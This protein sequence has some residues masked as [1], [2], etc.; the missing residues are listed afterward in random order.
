MTN[1]RCSCGFRESGDERLTDHLLEA[2]V[3][4]H[5]IGTDGLIHEEVAEELACSCGFRPA[6]ADELDQHFLAAFT[7][8][9]SVGQ[10]GKKHEPT[11]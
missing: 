5:S 4:P 7:P 11:A 8:P 6:I 10:D 3:P 2:F 9:Y 1:A